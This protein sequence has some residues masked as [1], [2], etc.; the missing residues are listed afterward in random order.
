MTA[1]VTRGVTVPAAPVA[2]PVASTHDAVWVATRETEGDN[3]I[4]P[5]TFDSLAALA[6]HADDP[7]VCSD[8][9]S[10]ALNS[11]FPLQARMNTSLQDVRAGQQDDSAQAAWTRFAQRVADHLN[12]QARVDG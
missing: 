8:P 12:A 11:L 6:M 2:V 5:F 9:L 1:P 7:M 10:V 4:E 3:T